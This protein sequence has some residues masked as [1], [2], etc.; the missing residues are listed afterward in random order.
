[1]LKWI[2]I[3]HKKENHQMKQQK[4]GTAT[5]THLFVLLL[6]PEQYSMSE[7]NTTLIRDLLIVD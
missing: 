6:P 7:S 1:M 5:N 3:K 4:K 2:K